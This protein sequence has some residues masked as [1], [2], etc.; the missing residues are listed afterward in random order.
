MLGYCSFDSEFHDTA[1]PDQRSVFLTQDRK[2]PECQPLI[3][4]EDG[5]QKCGR[6]FGRARP[7][8]GIKVLRD[9]GECVEAGEEW[10]IV[11]RDPPQ[12]EASRLQPVGT[13]RQGHF[14][15]SFFMCL[16]L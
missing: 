9:F 15:D 6:L 7:T 3:A 13:V 10:Q 8:S 2:I 12:H 5:P 11:H 4:V 1:A 14:G 16:R